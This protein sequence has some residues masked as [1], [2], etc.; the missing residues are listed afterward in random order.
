[1]LEQLQNAVTVKEMAKGQLHKVF[2]E[3]FA[4]KNIDN[5]QFFLQELHYIHLNP[6]RPTGRLFMEIIYW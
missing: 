1:M 2:T 3:S 6:Y 4:A 5:K